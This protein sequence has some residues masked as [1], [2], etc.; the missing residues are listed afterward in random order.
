MGCV[1]A[2]QGNARLVQDLLT[3]RVACQETITPSLRAVF[4]E[5][6]SQRDCEQE[7][8]SARLTAY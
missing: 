7:I 2:L 1:A 3:N 4:F 5:K 8:A 6:Q